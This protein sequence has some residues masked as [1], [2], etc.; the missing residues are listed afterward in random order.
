MFDLFKKKNLPDPRDLEQLIFDVAEHQSDKDFHL[1]YKVMANRHVFV[2]ADTNTIPAD[3]APGEK[4]T[5]KFGDRVSMRYVTGP[6][7][8]LLVPAATQE[9]A[10]ILKDGYLGMDWFDFLRMVLKLDQTFYGALLQGK[11][12]WVAFDRERIRYILAKSGA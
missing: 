12:S 1:L 9:S 8:L 2:P 7:N 10:P 4:Y 6:N 3:A 11:T 5:T